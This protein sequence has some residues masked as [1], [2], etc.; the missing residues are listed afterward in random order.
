MKQ[1]IQGNLARLLA[2]ENLTVLHKKGIAT[3]SFDAINRILSLPVW[4]TVS[5]DI[6]ETLIGHETGHAIYTPHVDPSKLSHIPADFINVVEDA[7]IEKLMKNKYPGMRRTFYEGYKQMFNN[8]FFE[9]D[10]IDVNQLNFLDKVNLYFKI[11]S[12]IEIQFTP[13]ERE[14]ID[15]VADVI[16]FDETMKVAELIYGYCKR[17][18]QLP[19]EA[20]YS[21]SL[22]PE[23][24][25]GE[26]CEIS[27][28]MDQ[29]GNSQSGSSSEDGSSKQDDSN[30]QL[31]SSGSASQSSTEGDSRKPKQEQNQSSQTG[32]IRGGSISR[33]M[34]SLQN[35]LKNIVSAN[36]EEIIYLTIPNIDLKK[37]IISP[38]KC[39]ESI[40]REI[41]R[42]TYFDI[43][44]SE[45]IEF[46]KKSKKDVGYLV[47]EFESR[48]AADSYARIQ[49]NKTGVL[50][51]SNLHSYMF[52]DDIFKKIT[53]TPEGKNHGL[54]FILD[55]SGSMQHILLP[56]LKQLYKLIWF[57][58]RVS[59]PFDVYAFTT[60][61]PV[62]SEEN[63]LWN[64]YQA[65]DQSLNKIKVTPNSGL[66]HFIDSKS[67]Y[68]KLDQQM[69]NIFILAS[70]YSVP[71]SIQR[72]V[73]F[74]G[75]LS[76]GGTP[77]N[78]SIIFLQQIIHQ[79]Q[80][81]KRV[82]K[83]NCVILSDGEGCIPTYNERT[84]VKNNYT[85]SSHY[86][87]NYVSSKTWLFDEKLKTTYNFPNYRGIRS[88]QEFT[89]VFLR[90]LKDLYPHVN[91]ISYRLISGGVSQFTSNFSYHKNP[92]KFKD[93]DSLSAEKSLKQTGV[94]SMNHCVYDSFFTIHT[95]YKA[96]TTRNDSPLSDIVQIR[97]SNTKMLS[98]FI[99][100]I[101]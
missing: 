77:L 66:L 47:K 81:E 19:P 79:F 60:E 17:T 5:D 16:E 18:S 38:R 50:N 9:L 89:D 53:M 25:Q 92:N 78:E 86:Q 39:H 99:S 90:N 59:I 12:H 4:E 41:S 8:N 76:L 67:S 23:D 49:E 22:S 80:K 73:N 21:I 40:S 75:F 35:N 36:P 55:W 45:Y 33:T 46:K 87:L 14:I 3:A 44:A 37:C 70:Y 58:Q 71:R 69:K 10:G 94:S 62:T 91:L 54:I 24:S 20:K 96:T 93:N 30:V 28:S 74:D 88:T 101:A 64:Q 13:E 61:I 68:S 95:G 6:Y 11:G 48:K 43:T 2:T 34:N 84:N 27:V 82:Q 65:N 85:G 1:E 7:R 31:Q 51:T 29:S 97:K 63:L 56:T 100:T 83:I 52:N 15:K 32:E 57:C 42:N 72:Y 26:G 98:Q